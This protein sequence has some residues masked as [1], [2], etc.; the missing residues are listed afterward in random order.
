[1][2]TPQ[3]QII[4]WQFDVRRY[5]AVGD[6]EHLDSPAINEA[7]ATASGRGGGCVVVPPGTYRCGTIRLESNVTLDLQSGATIV[8][9]ADPAD[10][11]DL[12]VPAGFPP[13]H[14]RQHTGV[15]HHL[16]YAIDAENVTLCGGG[17]I[18]G[19]VAAFTPGWQSKPPYTWT[20]PRD[21]PFVPMVDFTACRELRLLDVAFRDSPGWTVHLNHCDGV[22]VRGVRLRNYVYAGNSD[23]FDVNSCRDVLFSD[24]RIET[25]DDAIV[26]KSFREGRSSERIAIANCILRS[27]CAG[28]KIGT[29]TWHD[30]RQVTISNC[31]V[32]RSSRAVQIMSQ[33]GAAIEDVAVSNLTIDTDCGINLNRALHVDVHKRSMPHV[34]NP[35]LD[36]PV[37]RIRRV[38]MSNI[39]LRTDGRVLLTAGDGGRLEQVTLRDVSMHLPWIED[40]QS[41]AGQSDAMQSSPSNP[42]ARLARAAVVAENVADLRIEGLSIAWPD[43]GPLDEDYLPKYEKGR[44]VVDPRT[45]ATPAPPFHA[46]WARGIRGGRIDTR[47]LTGSA[48]GV[49]ATH[50]DDCDV[51]VD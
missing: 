13:Q 32:H 21:R 43:G 34:C 42:D 19:N 28:V 23:G 5:G 24:C 31:I 12:P 29:E 36:T 4:D 30:F 47:G 15:R 25:G 2:S 22:I 17:T 45:D 14:D 39:T 27:S 7:V 40:P 49:R 26:L 18:D 9:S 50:L 8:A 11:P 38:T 3:D 1:M 20:G 46:V 6:G 48:E 10:Y 16:L 44:L 33:D 35:D 41:S 51:T 37:G